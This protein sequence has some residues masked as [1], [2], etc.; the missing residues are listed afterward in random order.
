M[1]YYSLFLVLSQFLQKETLKT[2]KKTNQEPPKK[3]TIDIPKPENS[4]H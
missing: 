4:T 1:K 2:T 3:S